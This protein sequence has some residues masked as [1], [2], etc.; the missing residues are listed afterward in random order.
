MCQGEEKTQ[1]FGSL[2]A[3]K[4]KNMCIRAVNSRTVDMRIVE[5]DT[6]PCFAASSLDFYRGILRFGWVGNSCSNRGIEH[7]RELV[8][9]YTEHWDSLF[10]SGLLL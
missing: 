2:R 3:Y 4:L 9:P 1:G 7:Q 10:V 8:Y 5:I 6:A